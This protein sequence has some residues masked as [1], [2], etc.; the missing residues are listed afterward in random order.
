MSGIGR[1]EV[2]AGSGAMVLERLLVF[3]TEVIE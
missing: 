3:A 2:I 1:R